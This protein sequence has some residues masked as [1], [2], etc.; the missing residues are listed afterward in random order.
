MH[1]FELVFT[2]CNSFIFDSW[3]A[4]MLIENVQT[5]ASLIMSRNH[6]TLEPWTRCTRDRVICFSWKRVSF[7][8]LQHHYDFLYFSLQSP[9]AL[10]CLF[11]SLLFSLL[12]PNGITICN[13]EHV[14]YFIS[15]WCQSIMFVS[16][17]SLE[18]I[19]RSQRRDWQTEKQM[20]NIDRNTWWCQQR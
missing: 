20:S 17:I 12:V 18:R 16:V 6:K 7:H 15:C 13:G 11:L 9:L 14:C 2:P 3:M 10:F 4:W 1:D 8:S 19:Y 5:F